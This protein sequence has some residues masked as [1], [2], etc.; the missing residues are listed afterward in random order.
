MA[1]MDA[2]AKRKTSA[3]GWNQTHHPAHGL[4][5][6]LTELTQLIMTISS[7]KKCCDNT[8]LRASYMMVLITAG[9]T[10]KKN[11]TS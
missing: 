11:L 3:A 2:V 1:S 6:I 10:F 5:T 7:T 8:I 9:Q 4:V